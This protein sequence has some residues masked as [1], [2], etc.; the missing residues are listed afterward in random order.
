M[1]TVMVSGYFD[2]IHS[3]HMSY[4]REASKL[5]DR[6]IVIIDG[7]KRTEMKKGKSFLPASVRLDIIKEFQ[8]VNEVY[9]EDSDVKNS[10][11]QFKPDIFAK[12]GD[13]NSKENIP[14]WGLCKELG[15]EIITGVGCEKKTSSSNYLQDWVEFTNLLEEK[16]K[17]SVFEK[18]RKKFIEKFEETFKGA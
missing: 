13:R 16:K 3:G 4:I 11:R 2:P 14:E 9:V 15:I 18:G 7:D 12:G 10:L 5:G 1:K 6:L 8:C 17:L